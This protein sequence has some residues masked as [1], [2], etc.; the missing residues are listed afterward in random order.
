V[1]SAVTGGA[2]AGVSGASGSTPEQDQMV[3]QAQIA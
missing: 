2:V 1:I 3:A